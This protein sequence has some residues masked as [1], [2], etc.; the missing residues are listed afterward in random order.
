MQD[1]RRFKC[2]RDLI[3]AFSQFLLALRYSSTM[4]FL[5]LHLFLFF[6]LLFL[7]PGVIGLGELVNFKSSHGHIHD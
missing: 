6:A 2:N 1:F 3:R 5:L 4:V 7:N